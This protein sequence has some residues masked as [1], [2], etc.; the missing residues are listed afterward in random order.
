M[1]LQT[2]IKKT[3]ECSTSDWL[4][5][6]RMIALKI[7]FYVHLLEMVIDIIS[8]TLIHPPLSNQIIQIL[9][10]LKI[11]KRFEGETISNNSA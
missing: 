10:E 2:E 8:V 5:P 9:L 7:N 4:L 11:L 6:G 3:N 1:G